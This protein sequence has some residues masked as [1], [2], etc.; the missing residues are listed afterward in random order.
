MG[1][2]FQ[3]EADKKGFIVSL[4]GGVSISLLLFLILPFTQKLTGS[5]PKESIVKIDVTLPLPPPPPPPPPPE[6]EEEDEKPEMVEEQELLTLN[7][8]EIALNP[9]VGDV[10]I[11]ANL[12]PKVGTDVIADMKIF[13]LSEVDRGPRALVRINPKY[14]LELIRNKIKGRVDLW[15]VID[16]RGRVTDYKVKSSSHLSFTRAATGVI[17]KWKFSPAVKDGVPVTVRKI[18]PFLFG[19]Q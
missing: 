17:K 5:N 12:K 14:P 3:I 8:L 16:D 10:G 15:V 2:V 18:Q 7:Q 1:K 11:Y 6:L 9:G 13:D 19:E 4:L